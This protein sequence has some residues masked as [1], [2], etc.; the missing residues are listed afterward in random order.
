L[1]S[2]VKKRY[3][4]INNKNS[5][6]LKIYIIMPGSKKLSLVFEL[7]RNIINKDDINKQMFN[8]IN[9]LIKEN[10]NLKKEIKALKD[11]NIEIK[12]RLQNIENLLNKKEDKLNYYDFNK[13]KILQNE[14]EK[15]KLITWISINGKIKENLI[16]R[17][18]E[19]G[20]NSK[21]FYNKCKNKGPNI[22]LFK[23]NFK[24]RFGGFTN[25]DLSDNYEAL[26]LKDENAF[27]FSL[28]LL[29]KYNVLN[30]NVAICCYPQ[31]D[32][33]L[34]YGN[35][36]DLDGIN[37]VVEFLSSQRCFEKH[38]YRAYDV[39]NNLLLSGN[40]YFSLEEVEVYQIIFE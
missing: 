18:T 14:E 15:K 29:Q 28:D 38:K 3:S 30:P 24:K 35:N 12:K 36:W 21:S 34:S 33:F 6:S 16:Y 11:E 32:G 26:R 7:D 40:D 22:S 19:D 25:A 1:E 23:S 5:M 37:I 39:P 10:N 27:L 2:I 9:E 13:S 4:I 17:A 8:T 31:D 20:D